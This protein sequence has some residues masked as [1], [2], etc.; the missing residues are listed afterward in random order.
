MKRLYIDIETRSRVDLKKT[1]VYR[2]AQCPD[3]RILMA[4][5]AVDGGPIKIAL[6]EDEIRGIPGLLDP[7]VQKVAHNAQ[8]ER[9]CFSR[10]FNLEPGEYLDPEPWHDTQAV[11]GELGWPQ[12]LE[13]LG[14]ALGTDEKDSAG[15]RLINTFCV[16]N[17]KREWNTAE[18]HPIEWLDFIAYCEQDVDTLRQI[19]RELD[20]RGN[21]PTDLER[22]LFL[23]DQRINDRGIAIDVELAERAVESGTQ[24]MEEQKARVTELTGV[25]NPN[26]VIQMKKWVKDQGLDAD[27]LRAE[28]VQKL[29]EGNL[30]PDQREV[31]ELRQEL[32]LAAPKK[33][34]SAL[35]AEVGGRIR[36]TLKFF[37]AHTGRWAG[38]GTQ[39]QNLPRA[40]FDS[41]AEEEAAIFDLKMGWGASSDHLKR[42]VR[43]L[44]VGPFTVV[45][46][47]AIEARVVAWLAGEKWALE[48][49]RGGRDIYVETAERMSTPNHTLTRFQGKVAVLALG[50]NGGVNSLRAMGADGDDEELKRLVVQWRRANSNIV[51]LWHLLGDAF[52]EKNDTAGPLLRVEEGQDSLGRSVK[53][54]LPSGRAITYHGVKWERYRV[55]DPKTGRMVP[56]EGWRYADPKNPFNYRQR[57]GTYGGRLTENATQAVARDIMAEAL[58]RLEDRGYRVVAHVHDEIIVEGEHDVEEISSI[59]TEVPAWAKGL[60][61]DGEGFT[62]QRYRKG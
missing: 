32:A 24:N 40:A 54:W 7:N 21:W 31:L 47:S 17:R 53:M 42:L 36:G 58:V 46:Y 23:A 29:L 6:S 45:D 16:P 43:P 30:Q 8:F 39:L 48:A 38:R 22:K 9:I 44:F 41:E 50:Y 34:E 2:Y 15:T 56:K 35:A 12:S 59:M 20:R 61:V 1:G 55:Q 11:A 3:F 33:F 19:A 13:M 60:P 18:T 4:A 27:D 25:D 49:F 5:Y 51:R 62:C 14:K 10:F 52:G 26:S 57:I 37:G 28:T